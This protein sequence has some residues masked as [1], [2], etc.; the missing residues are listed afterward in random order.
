MCVFFQMFQRPVV[1]QNISTKCPTTQHNIPWELNL[2][3][4]TANP[5]HWRFHQLPVQTMLFRVQA[6]FIKSLVTEICHYSETTLF[7]VTV[8]VC[9]CS[10]VFMIYEKVHNFCT[11]PN[12]NCERNWNTQPMHFY[13]ILINVLCGL[14][15]SS[16]I[17]FLTSHTTWQL[18]G[19]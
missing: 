11:W 13:C 18:K 1:P 8:N 5:G 17:V 19:N 12:H 6:T 15:A 7:W 16:C 9:L 2:Q 14:K 3:P 4:L 10:N